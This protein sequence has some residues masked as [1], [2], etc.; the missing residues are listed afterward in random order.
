MC[1]SCAC[2]SSPSSDHPLDL[3]GRILVEIICLFTQ[4]G[5]ETLAFPSPV[6]DLH[7]GHAPVCC[8]LSAN[9]LIHR[10]P[11]SRANPPIER[12]DVNPRMTMIFAYQF[13]TRPPAATRRT[14]WQVQVCTRKSYLSRSSYMDMCTDR[15]VIAWN[16]A[17]S[18][19][20]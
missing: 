15:S 13:A 12:Q 18:R 11:P 5:S 10:V 4:P 8:M 14:E 6:S 19:F 7:Y 9:S 17:K 3:H 20:N 1:C 2:L 16:C